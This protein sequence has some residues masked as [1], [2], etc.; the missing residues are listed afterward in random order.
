MALMM[1][2]A[3]SVYL[4]MRDDDLGFGHVAGTLVS[5]VA[6]QRPLAREQRREDQ[7]EQDYEDGQQQ[8]GSTAGLALPAAS[9][10]CVVQV[11][12]STVQCRCLS[13]EPNSSTGT[14]YLE[15]SVSDCRSNGKPR[16]QLLQELNA[17]N[18]ASRCLPGNPQK[19]LPPCPDP[20]PD[21]QS[22]WDGRQARAHV[23]PVEN[24]K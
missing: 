2:A 4:N 8:A 6:G 3:D 21:Q 5:L 7:H 24:E 23:Q 19:D 14:R 12:C 11:R 15:S 1:Q 13:D 22:P 17:C 9:I 16:P 10:S 20:G 18:A